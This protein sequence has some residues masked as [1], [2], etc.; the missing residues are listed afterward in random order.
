MKL[1]I[2]SIRRGYI[3][4]L[5]LAAFACQSNDDKK[6]K[7]LITDSAMV[8]TA[9]PLASQVGAA[10]LKKGGNA[11]DAAVA[12]QFALAVVFPAAGNIGGGGYMITR[13]NDGTVS[14]LDYRE[15]APALAT[16]DMY[17]D[18]DG[19]VIPDLS[20]EGHLASGVPGSVDGMVEAH[21]KYGSLPWKELVQ[22]AIDLALNGFKLTSRE[23]KWFNE[24]RNDLIK[25]NTMAGTT[26]SKL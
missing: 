26:A 18:K 15:K 5:A 22:P 16:T 3:L 21:K 2:N 20:T 19:N 6:A 8:V 11:V 24:M 1:K 12:T 13:M 4:L 9:H 7:G 14:A 10:I 25:Y 17:L 23:A